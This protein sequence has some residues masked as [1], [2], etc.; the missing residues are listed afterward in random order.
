MKKLIIV[1]I[2]S[3]L[4]F[5][6]VYGVTRLTFEQHALKPEVHNNMI[7]TKFMDP[8]LA[9]PNQVWDFSTLHKDKNFEGSIK[10][11]N[12][13]KSSSFTNQFNTELIEF[14]N[15]FYFDITKEKIELTGYRSQN[16]SVLINYEKPFLKMVYPFE[17]GNSFNGSF[18][19]T[20]T[21]GNSTGEINGS[22]DVEADGY[23]KLILPN[24]VVVENALRVKTVKSYTQN[25][26]S[27]G[28]QITVT[29]Y[30]WYAQN[31]RYPLLVLIESQ[32]GA[33]EN[34]NVTKQAA[35]REDISGLSVQNAFAA[36]TRL[37][38]NPFNNELNVA[39]ELNSASYVTVELFD[40]AGKNVAIL[41]NEY[42]AEGTYDESFNVGNL[43]L[44]NGMYNIKITVNG[45]EVT[46]NLVHM[47]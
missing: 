47:K 4:V 26:G 35:Y 3:C 28:T 8:G 16:G 44:K 32:Y 43:N 12:T 45:K 41:M 11:P 37:Y 1:A 38:P 46:H 5:S 23:G 9:G 22:Y 20:I 31:V 39:F 42:R 10:F 21:S 6:S 7:L 33:G 34:T 30:R 29:T 18:N 25:F 15:S 27:T 24:S 40:I 36:N 17:F 13:L 14:G 2:A 19:G